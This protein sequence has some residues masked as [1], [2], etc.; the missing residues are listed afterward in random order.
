MLGEEDMTFSIDKLMRKLILV[1]FIISMVLLAGCTQVSK[2]LSNTK[3]TPNI[4]SVSIDG[5][6]I[7]HEQHFKTDPGYFDFDVVIVRY[8][9]RHTTCYIRNNPSL[10]IDGGGISCIPDNYYNK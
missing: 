7:I 5:G 9:N 4:E 10:S 3:I 1:I 6:V 2:P 8:E